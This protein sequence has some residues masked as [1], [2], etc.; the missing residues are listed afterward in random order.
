MATWSCD[1]YASW[2]KGAVENVNGRLQRDKFTAGMAQPAV[3]L[4]EEIESCR[5]HLSI[6]APLN[7]ARK[8]PRGLRIAAPSPEKPA[9]PA[10]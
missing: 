3:Q 10:S 8:P 2:Q 4:L 1:A 6:P 7:P 5:L 9:L